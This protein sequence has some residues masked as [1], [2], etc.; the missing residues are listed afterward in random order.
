MGHLSIPR[1]LLTLGYPCLASS[2]PLQLAAIYTRTTFNYSET[3]G[4]QNPVWINGSSNIHQG[5]TKHVHLINDN[6]NGVLEN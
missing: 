1:P 3:L 6:E 4:P 2:D 5:L